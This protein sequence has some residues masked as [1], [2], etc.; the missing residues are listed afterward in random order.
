MRRKRSLHRT[1]VR[2]SVLLFFE[3]K[4]TREREVIS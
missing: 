2:G 4:E 3:S 1:T